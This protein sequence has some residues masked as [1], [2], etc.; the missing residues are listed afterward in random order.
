MK[1]KKEVLESDEVEMLNH[2]VVVREDIHN[3]IEQHLKTLKKLKGFYSKHR[4]I[5]EAIEEKIERWKKIDKTKIGSDKNLGIRIS[6]CIDE[7]VSTIL[8]ELKV[9]GKKYCKKDFFLEAIQEKLNRDVDHTKELLVKF[10]K[11]SQRKK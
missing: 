6:G 7:K 3:E 2:M 1:N 8:S 10:I 5:Q 4:F 9:L 11:N